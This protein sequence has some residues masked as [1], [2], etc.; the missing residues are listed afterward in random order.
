LVSKP[1][2][3]LLAGIQQ[4]AGGVIAGAVSTE[5]FPLVIDNFARNMLSHYFALFIGFALP[6]AVLTLLSHLLPP[7]D[8]TDGAYVNYDKDQTA[9]PASL[10]LAH[11]PWIR[12]IPLA[13]HAFL[14]GTLIG[15]SY[16]AA[17]SS[18]GLIVVIA[19][20]LESSV[21]GALTSA[22]LR[23]KGFLNVVCIIASVLLALFLP[24]GG[25]VGA[26]AFSSSTG[27]LLVGF[28]S[29]GVS[30]LT[31]LV[32]DDL[33]KEG[34]DKMS[35]ITKILFYVGVIIVIF[36]HVTLEGHDD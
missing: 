17:S 18:A 31:F 36:V 5:L 28:V 34:R 13:V 21:L 2:S 26:A 14:D 20:S 25:A 7:E 4:L 24:I 10:G 23:Q 16:T 27:A 12:L 32:I 22:T 35:W 29:F 1:N 8:S 11:L 6:I 33:L 3:R 9:V 19:F 30:T 15:L